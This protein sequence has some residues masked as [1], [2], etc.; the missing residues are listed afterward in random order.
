MSAW[1]NSMAEHC[2]PACKVV[3]YSYSHLWTGMTLCA[4]SAPPLSW[5]GKV[6][7][8]FV[9]ITDFLYQAGCK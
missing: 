8:P 2:L 1:L 5:N 9:V 4:A 3:P 7:R 6:S